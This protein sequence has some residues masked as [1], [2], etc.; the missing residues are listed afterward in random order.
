MKNI[1]LAVALAVA[2]PA[3]AQQPDLLLLGKKEFEIA[4]AEFNLGHY[5]KALEHFEASY[6]LTGKPALLYNIGFVH[7]HLW[8]RTRT[9]A[10]L[11]QA[12]D[13]YRAFLAST[14]SDSDP[15]V[16]QLRPKVENDLA[17][18]EEE[19]QAEKARRAKGEEALEFG[20]ELLSDGKLAEV[21]AELERF[22]HT[23]GN[24][25]QSVAH[26]HILRGSLEVV[27]GDQAAA[28]DEYARALTLAPSI[29]LAA[30]APEP[31]K[32]AFAAAQARVGA[33]PPVG[34]THAPPGSLPPNGAVELVFALQSDPMAIVTGV[35]LHYRAGGG[36]FS[37]LPPKPVGR[38]SLPP[39]FATA[40]HPGQR[41]EYYGEALDK[42]GALLE[43]LGTAALPFSV[44]VA[45]PRG[46]SV[47]KK[48][49]FWTAT[50]GVVAAAAVGIGLG[51]YY[52]QPPPPQKVPTN[53]G[54]VQW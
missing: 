33:R 32:A 5:D 45:Q 54:L 7:A 53:L 51:V 38:V 34:V 31:A 2:A 4:S 6:R 12:I 41:V 48:W 3:L 1:A 37:T 11:E 46:P 30:H 47:V 13:R 36:A 25:R 35:R 42:N 18:A 8:Q 22:E 44:T 39:L 23:P 17:A 15:R 21:E 14:K 26:A 16:L 10:Q 29:A 24:E 9:L 20:W 40:L 52:S 19:L 49:W 28:T 50:V 27:R 43:H